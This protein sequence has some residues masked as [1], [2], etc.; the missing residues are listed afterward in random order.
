MLPKAAWDATVPAS[1]ESAGK[2]W[3]DTVP[4]RP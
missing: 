3:S 1:P 2:G 4:G